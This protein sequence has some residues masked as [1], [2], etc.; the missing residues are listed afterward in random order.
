ME[1]P[2]TE[3]DISKEFQDQL[4]KQD[5]SPQPRIDGVQIIDL[6]LFTDEGG[7]FMELGRYTAGIHAQ[8]PNF[9]IKQVNYSEMVPSLIKGT[10]VH[11]QQEDIWFIPPN[12]RLLVGLMDVREDSPT[13]GVKMR[14]VMGA[15]RARLLYIPR[16]VAHAAA[17]LWEKNA[18][19]VYFVNNEFSAEPD[20]T[21]ERRLPWDIFGEGFWEF[22][23]E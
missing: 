13:K 7:H 5:Y 6:P 2:L 8:F 22:S 21:D 10:H 19:I 1:K 23:K 18:A 20:T 12:H 9:E 17:N 14:F 15:G 16:G 3:A 4:S 11:F